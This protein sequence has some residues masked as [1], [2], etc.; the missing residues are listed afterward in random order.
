VDAKKK[1]RISVVPSSET[2]RLMGLGKFSLQDVLDLLGRS[3]LAETNQKQLA[4]IGE[5]TNT[6]RVYVFMNHLAEDMK[7]VLFSQIYEW[8]GE[9]IEPQIDNPELQNV[10]YDLANP[11]WYEELSRN[12]SILGEVA[13]F[14]E[15]ERAS[16]EPQGIKSLLV[17]PIMTDDFF[18]GFIGLDSVRQARQWTRPE[19]GLLRIIAA[20]FGMSVSQAVLE[21]RLRAA[22]NDIQQFVDIVPMGVVFLDPAG[23]FMYRNHTFRQVYGWDE[24][25][26]NRLSDWW[27]HAYS[28]GLTQDA[29]TEFAAV[30]AN[31]AD[32][33]SY[34]NPHPFP[35]LCKD[36]MT[37]ITEFR[38]VRVG[39]NLAV[40]L[41][42]VSDRIRLEELHANLE[43]QKRRNQL[44]QLESLERMAG[45]IA[46][47]FNNQLSVVMGALDLLRTVVEKH[48]EVMEDFHLAL[49]ATKRAA[50]VS[51]SMLT[52]LGEGLEPTETVDIASLCRDCVEKCQED[53]F[54]QFDWVVQ[55]PDR[56]ALVKVN[57]SRMRQIFQNLFQNAQEAMV[58]GRMS[59]QLEVKNKEDYD[60]RRLCMLPIEWAPQSAQYVSIRVGDQGIGI[61]PDDFYRV[62]EPFFTTKFRGR[63][64]GLAMAGGYL[65]AW[66]GAISVESELG[67][68]SVFTVYLPLVEEDAAEG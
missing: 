26:V 28:P 48:P 12:R 41:T 34:T 62:F 11:R 36:G 52:Y 15:N 39:E 9:G 14:P 33:D 2:A 45:S 46:H 37:R 10:P 65:K 1:D 8:S 61:P 38:A 53:S 23:D 42:D 43:E 22:E 17:V 59:V 30:L 19:E 55:I 66:N 64:M 63:G 21:K 20:D 32:G 57:A 50:E 29:K 7:T 27:E 25:T 16:L 35:V 68:G 6:D 54:D 5:Y 18:W 56:K 40:I 49:R 51:T 60:G 4:D 24:S 3:K 47:V 58:K 67:K 31:L 44:R 13:D